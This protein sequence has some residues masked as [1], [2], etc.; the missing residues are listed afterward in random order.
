VG[1]IWVNSN[2]LKRDDEDSPQAMQEHA[3]QAGYRSPYVVD[4]DNQLADAFGAKTT[5]HVFLF[6]AD[7]K[8][9]YRGSIDN[10]FE[11]KNKKADRFYLKKAL[12]ALAMDETIDPADTREIGCS[13][14]R[15]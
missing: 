7:Q 10:K 12:N 3:P 9:V 6:D 14:K 1:V 15:K 5:P 2:T 13:I 8:L 11:N 4:E